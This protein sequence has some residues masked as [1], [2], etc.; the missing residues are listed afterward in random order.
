M[1]KLKGAITLVATAHVGGKA[2]AFDGDTPADMDAFL[3]RIGKKATAVEV[4]M[5]AT[6][7]RGES[8]SFDRKVRVEDD[9][10]GDELIES[11]IAD[12]RAWLA[13]TTGSEG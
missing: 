3:S 4:R 6:T 5:S 1:P 13:E 8:R 2:R 7:S 12:A 11:T 10:A 9:A